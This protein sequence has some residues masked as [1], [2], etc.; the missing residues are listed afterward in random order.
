V[1]KVFY[2]IGLAIGLGIAAIVAWRREILANIDEFNS[3][4]GYL[5]EECDE[6]D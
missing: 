2:G 1:N 3:H 5:P 4:I 6:N